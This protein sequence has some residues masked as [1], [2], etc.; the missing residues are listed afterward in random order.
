VKTRVV[1]T[2]ALAA[3]A[4]IA[5]SAPSHAPA[6]T[7]PPGRVQLSNEKTVTRWAYAVARGAAYARP[8]SKARR[9]ARLRF[10]TEDGFPEVY[11]AL[12]SVRDASGR[13]WVRVRLPQRPNNMAGWA[14]RSAL[15]DFHVVHTKIVVDRRTLRLTLYDRGRAT[16]RARVGVGK[17][18]TPT[19]AGSFWIREKFHTAGNPLYGTRAM[20]TAAYSNTLTDWPGGGIIGLHGTSEPRLIPGRP[21]HGCVRLR[22]RDIVRLYA[23]APVGTPLLIR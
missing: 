5:A 19:P 6:A 16:F 14:L 10:R 17:P 13:T 7:P 12:A 20:G 18:S 21:S 8:S 4:S 1:G 15:S 3:I 11:L 22:N 2:A 9:V 23:L